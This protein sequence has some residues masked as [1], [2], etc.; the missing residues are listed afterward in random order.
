MSDPMNDLSANTFLGRGIAFPMRVDHTGA[1]AMTTG[2]EDIDRSIV[3]V[4]S[5]AKGERL[6]R[7]QFGCTIWDQ[8]FDPINA[9]TLGRMAQGVRD[10]LAQWEPR[11]EVDDV[12]VSDDPLNDG[13]VLIDITYIVKTT[14]DRRNLVYPFYVI[15]REGEE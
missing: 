1:I 13:R 8:M 9:N 4:I 5:T 6:M 12:V 2:A 11:V 10:A 15:P 3:M 14:N 7:P